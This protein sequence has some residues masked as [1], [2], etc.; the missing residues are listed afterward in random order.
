[1]GEGSGLH[2]LRYGGVSLPVGVAIV[3]V[4]LVSAVVSRP[5]VAADWIWI[6]RTGSAT[7]YLDRDSAVQDGDAVRCLACV[8]FETP[9]KYENE[10]Y[11]SETR[12]YEVD[13]SS[14]SL[15]LVGRSGFALLQGEGRRLFQSD[16]LREPVAEERVRSVVG[17]QM[18]ALIEAAVASGLLPVRKGS[19]Q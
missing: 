4:L 5:L 7:L 3:V 11:R 9:R 2:R 12:L 14:R 19:F 1:M 15:W 6:A 8:D 16:G 18:M 10:W 13:L 17:R